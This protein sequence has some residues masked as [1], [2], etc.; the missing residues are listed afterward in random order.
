MKIFSVVLV[1][2][3]VVFAATAQTNFDATAAREMS[4]PDCIQEALQHNLALQIDRYNPQVSLYNLRGAYGGYDPTLNIS[5]QHDFNVSP[6]GFTSQQIPLPATTSKSDSFNSS[7]NGAL[8]WGLQYDFS[9]NIADRTFQSST[10]PITESTSGSIGVSLTQPLL[11]NFWIDS[12]RLTIRV[13]RNRLKFSEQALRGQVISTVTAVAIAYY[14]LIYAK[15][16]VLVQQQALQLAQTQLDQDKQRVQLGSL[17]PLDVQQ[18]Q[19]QAAQSEASLI[20]AQ[21]TLNTDQNTLKN[22]LTDAYAQWH[23][24]NIQ[25]TATLEAPLELFDLQDSWSKG[26][27]ERP[28]LLQAR[29][30]VERQ[31]IQLKFDRNQLFPQL[32]LIGSYGFNGA[33]KEFNGTFDQFNQG[34]APFYTYGAK[35]SLPLSNIGARNVYKSDKV[36]ESQLLLTL[37]QLEQ[38]IMVQID[39]TVKQAQSDYQSVNATRSARTYAEAAL[40]AEQKKYNVGKSTTFTVLQLQNTL[41]ADRAAEIRALANYNEDLANLSQQEGSTLERNGI[42]IEAK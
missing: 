15:E 4:L 23:D 39:N 16:N 37:K 27:T 42:D 38:T 6:G 34:N 29:L 40:D 33:S 36:T 28:D 9:G 20:A 14:E 8:P 24:T 11:K 32:D 5:G 30:D 10:N 19:A 7:V 3:Q 21:S 12:T 41:T 35:L 13:A 17:A 26:M 2:F 1:F 22:L 25:P 18:D 31:G